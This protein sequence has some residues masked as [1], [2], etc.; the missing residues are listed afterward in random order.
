MDDGFFPK[1]YTILAKF[2]PQTKSNGVTCGGENRKRMDR[3]DGSP[4][5][6]A[7]TM[8][9]SGPRHTGNNSKRKEGE[10]EFECEDSDDS[11][12][13]PGI[14]CCGNPDYPACKT[15]CSLFDDD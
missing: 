6:G 1:G 7:H 10:Y 12:D 13:I 15:W 11:F 14:G 4:Q 5:K 3:A 8:A 9:K 2:A